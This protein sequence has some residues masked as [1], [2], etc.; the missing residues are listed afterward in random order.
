MHCD[1]KVLTGQNAEYVTEEQKKQLHEI[2]AVI[3]S[4]RSPVELKELSKQFN[5]IV[6]DVDKQKK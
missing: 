4:S 6:E 5:Q 3:E 2:A 1:E